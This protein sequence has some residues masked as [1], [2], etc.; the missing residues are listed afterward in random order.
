[1]L[2]R[3]ALLVALTSGLIA[4]GRMPAGRTAAEQTPADKAQADRLAAVLKRSAEYCHRLSGAAL[5]F[6]CLEEV[7]EF[8]AR[9]TPTTKI[10]LYDYQFVKKS[11]ET[12]EKRNLVALDGKKVEARESDLQAV[13]FHYENVLFGPVGLLSESWQAYHEYKFVGEEGSGPEKT[14]VIDAK[15][16]PVPLQAHCFGRLWVREKDGAVLKIVWD[17]KS[18]GNYR[19]VDEWAR[20]HGAEARITAFCE[21]KIEKNGLRFPSRNYSEQA[22]LYPDK[23]KIVTAEISVAYKDYKF[24]TVETEVK[25]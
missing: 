24:F 25:Y 8:T 3:I 15:P 5:D 6:V 12:K 23:G 21:Y 18:L 11:Q 14:L 9:F 16:G 1:M 13:T 22:Y 19:D 2:R 20:S 7:K 4:A 10:Y 17:Q